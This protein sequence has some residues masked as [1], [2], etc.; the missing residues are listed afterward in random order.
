[1]AKYKI[2]TTITDFGAYATKLILELPCEIGKNDIGKHSFNVYVERKRVQSGEIIL[3]GNMFHPGAP[4]KP[5]KG[6]QSVIKAYPSDANSN[7]QARGTYVTLELNEEPLGKRIEGSVLTSEYINNDYRVTLLHELPGIVPTSGLVFDECAGEICPQT[8][9]WDSGECK[10][11]A[12]RLKYG[13]F[14]PDFDLLDNPKPDFFGHVA[15]P[16]PQKLPLVIWLHGAGEGGLDTRTAYTGNKVVNISDSVIQKKLGG[17]AWI[18]VPQ[19]PTVWMDDGAEK[20]GRSNQS[21]YVEPLKACI[22]EFIEEH[23]DRIDRKRIYI[24]GCSN[25]GFMTVRMLIDYPDFFA[26]AYPACQVFFKDNIT[27]D[28][29]KKLK[30]IPIWFSHAEPDELVAPMETTIPLYKSLKEAGAENVHFSYFDHME[31]LSGI[32]KDE[33]GR[34][35]RYFNHAVWVHVYNDDCVYDFDGT[36]V[37]FDGVPVTLWGWIGKQSK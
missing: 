1:M 4:A 29:I 21:I 9:G 37:M 28:I 32:Y 26:A 13:Y 17:A 25:G 8:K 34:P 24:G 15:A 20:L 11:G 23:E 7:E 14:K 3:A 22:D 10:T 5:S 35:Q 18:L 36:Q 19:C 27:E 16:I 30:D 12:R 31:D 33:K 2:F 6:Y